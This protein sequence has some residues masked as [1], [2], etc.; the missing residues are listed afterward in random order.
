MRRGPG[1]LAILLVTVAFG[2]CQGEGP[3]STSVTSTL[4]TLDNGA[5]R[6]RYSRLPDSA[7]Q[8]V[9]PE[10]TIG[11]LE[12]DPALVFGDVRGIEADSEGTIY[13]LDYQAAEIRTFDATGAYLQTIAKRGEG[14][15]ELTDANGMILVGDSVLWVQDHGKMQMLAL[16]TD[17]TELR[18]YPMHVMNYGYMWNGTVDDAGRFWKPAHHS[19]E[20]QRPFPPE[21]GFQEE[22]FRAYMVRFD[23]TTEVRDSVP[24]GTQTYRSHVSRNSRGGYTHSEVPFEPRTITVIDPGGGLWATSGSGYRIARLDE[25]G[26]TVLVLESDVPLQAVTNQDRADYVAEAVAWDE[27]A[28][29]TAEEVVAAMPMTRPAISGLSMDD[30]GNLWVRRGGTEDRFPRYDLFSRSGDYQGSVALDFTPSRY[31]PLKLRNGKLYALM[32]GDMDV[33]LVVRAT[34]PYQVLP[35]L[36][37]MQ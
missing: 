31:L 22:T 3:A 17:G 7:S 13:V 15:G 2:G 10:L 18:R 4:D 12:G 23:P 32:L 24:M 25:E 6:I 14:P 33:P 36:P 9:A 16:G 8:R 35:A 30:A 34:V 1:I 29:R 28:A 27:T 37:P 11:M 5:L 21:L 20:P 19:T 26:D